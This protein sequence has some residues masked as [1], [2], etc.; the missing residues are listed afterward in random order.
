MNVALGEGTCRS[1]FGARTS[2]L[3]RRRMR[4][5]TMTSSA[6]RSVQ[7]PREDFIMTIAFPLTEIDVRN[8]PPQATCL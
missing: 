1:C 2:E 4:P 8:E 3:L 5:R 6:E 7:E